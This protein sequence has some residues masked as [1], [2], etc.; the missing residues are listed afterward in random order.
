MLKEAIYHRPKNNY[1]YAYNNETLHIRLRTKKDD[2]SSVHLIHG[3]PYHWED[4]AWQINKTE[5]K[6]SG[7]TELFDYWFVEIKPPFRRLRYGFELSNHEETIVYAERG[8][9]DE[10]PTDDTAYYFCFPFLNEADIFKAP[11]W[12]KDTVWYQI[13][14]ERFAN[15]DPSINPKGTLEWESEEPATNNFFG[16]DFEGV[17]QH[18]DHLVELGIGGI[19]FTPIF[20]AHSNHKY[21]TIDYMEIDPQFGTKETFK[22]L[23][24]ECHERNIKVMLDAVFNHSGY[25]FEPFQDVLQKQEKSIYKDWFHLKEFPIVTEPTPNYDAFAFVPSMP[26][27]N[28]EHPDVKAYLLEVGKYWAKE[29]NIDGWRLDVANEVDHAFWREFRTAVKSVNPD[30][31][32]LGEIWHDSMPW[33]QGDQFDAVMNYPFTN[34][35]L[36]FF[37]KDKISAEDF[38]NVISEVLHS[39]PQNVNEVAFNLLGSHDTPRVLTICDEKI[40]KLKLLYTFQLSFP[41]APCIYYGDEIGMTGKQDPGCRKCMVWDEERQDRDL[42]EYV[43][44]LLKLRKDHKAIGSE[45]TFSFIEANNENNTIVYAKTFESDTFVYILSNSPNELSVKTPDLFKNKT[46]FNVITEKNETYNTEFTIEGYG[47]KIIR[48]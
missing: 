1:A 38:T 10:I 17:I 11:S 22:R 29:F 30:L 39:Y 13:F 31:Y 28:T 42:F 26:K 43:Q 15:G 33:L 40:E 6:I 25:F 46:V 36:D 41:G 48:L 3:D 5:M 18:L 27:L 14:P 16:G 2:V 37:A 45:G 19:Y 24:D 20:K 9:Y 35:A 34:G 4:G 21:D 23:V 32:I 7:S 12:A 8:F 47:I 44:T